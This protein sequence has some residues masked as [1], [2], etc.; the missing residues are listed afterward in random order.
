MGP[1]YVDWAVTSSCDLRCRH[2]VGMGEEEL[3]HEEAIEVT[4][5]IIEISPRWVILEGGEP[6]LRKDLV[7][8]GNMLKEDDIDVFVI[9][10]GNSFSPEKLRELASFSPKILFSVDGANSKLYED[11]KLGADFETAK[12]WARECSAEGIFH[13]ITTV[14]S[15]RN[16]SQAEELIELTEGLGGKCIVFIPLKPFGTDEE[17]REYYDRYALSPEDHEWAIRKIFSYESDLDVFYDEPF[18][19][20]VLSE[21]GLSLDS[22][23]SGIT[24]P[25]VE[26]CAAEYSMYIW[27]NGEV[28]PCMFCPE[29]LS[30]GN[31]TEDPLMDI[32]KRMKQSPILTGWADQV[33]RE[34]PCGDCSQFEPCHGCLARTARLTNNTKEA[35][36]CCPLFE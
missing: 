18:V 36:L 11:T 33:E 27:T 23:N 24:I 6:L 26:G 34:A 20:N 30:F 5:E 31:A 35:D 9:T 32:W 19:W 16:L 17:S 13:G 21:L 10:N 14:L 2:C 1:I 4:R 28:R 12:K 29:Q 22:D 7:E 8:I 3:D 15:K 25:D